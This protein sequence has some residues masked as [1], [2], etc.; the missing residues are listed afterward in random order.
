[1]TPRLPIFV[2]EWFGNLILREIGV[3]RCDHLLKQFAKRSYH[4]TKQAHVVSDSHSAAW[5][6]VR[7]VTHGGAW[8]TELPGFSC[9]NTLFR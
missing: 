6:A 1:M 9:A 2:D 3:A 7:R 8:G 5:M 4:H